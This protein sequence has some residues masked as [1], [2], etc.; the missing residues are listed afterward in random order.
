M[1][2]KGENHS[3]WKTPDLQEINYDFQVEKY[4]G[5]MKYGKGRE[6]RIAR[7]NINK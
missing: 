6:K 5:S 1:T 3:W 4:G 2:H 7:P